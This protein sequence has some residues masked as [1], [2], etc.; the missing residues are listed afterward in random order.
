MTKHLTLLLFIGLA[1]WGCGSNQ[2]KEV[3][4]IDEEYGID[5]GI[6]EIFVTTAY[7]CRLLPSP[8]SNQ[9]ILRIPKGIELRV[10]DAQDIQQG[11]MLNKWYKV[12]Y[13]NKT[14]WTSGWNMVNTPELRILSEDEMYS[15]YER[16]IGKSP[17]NNPLTGKIP[18]ID[19][20][21]KQNNSNYKNIE[22]TQWYKPFVMNDQWVCRLQYKEE[23]NGNLMYEDLLFYFYDGEIVDIQNYY[24]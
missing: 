23:I 6:D 9:Q 21:L 11:R 2:E 24:D 14:G 1:F 10:L 19:K 15:N 16:Q 7:D 3:I 8:N 4:K 22:Y 18:E 13:N 12:N 20:W 17:V 5:S